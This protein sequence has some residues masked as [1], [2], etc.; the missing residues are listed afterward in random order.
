M[1][2][3]IQLLCDSEVI[4]VEIESNSAESF[5][6]LYYARLNKDVRRYFFNR[7]KKEKSHVNLARITSRLISRNSS[8]ISEKSICAALADCCTD[9]RSR[10]QNAARRH[11]TSVTSDIAY[12]G[13][14]QS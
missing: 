14:Y 6:E 2:Q 12:H 3:K 13:T 8:E 7:L 1:K 11:E 5:L 9:S 4:S 10:S